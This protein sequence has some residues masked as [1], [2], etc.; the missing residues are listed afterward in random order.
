MTYMLETLS[1]MRRKQEHKGNAH[2]VGMYVIREDF[3]EVTD[4]EE[5][6]EF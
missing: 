6:E 2:W 4:F 3:S 1:S 5:R